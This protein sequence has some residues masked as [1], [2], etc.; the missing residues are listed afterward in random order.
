MAAHQPRTGEPTGRWEG[1]WISEGTGHSGRLR[2]VVMPAG[3]GPASATEPAAERY[4]V[5]FH[6]IWGG[7]FRFGQKV[8]MTLQPLE[9]GTL[10]LSGQE[11]LGYLAGGLYKYSGVVTDDRFL[12]KYNSKHD[13]GLFRMQ[14]K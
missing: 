11:D 1:K 7:I 2:A 6:A 3:P 14:R 8:E 9:D 13:H 10:V 4:I 5:H 12:C